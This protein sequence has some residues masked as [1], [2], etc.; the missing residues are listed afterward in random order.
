[1]N[2]NL[3]ENAKLNI[4]DGL[5]N[6]IE[7]TYLIE[8]EYKNLTAS[9]TNLQN[10]I[11][12]IV[13]ILPTAIWV[14]DED[15]SV[16]LQNSEAAKISNLLKFIGSNDGEIELGGMIYLVKTTK[17]D[18]K[19][20]VSAT[21][22]TVEKR[23]ERL[24]SMGQVA[25]HLAHEIRNPVGSIS[26]L[27]STLAKRVDEKS[28]PIVTEI[29]KAIH[30]VERII[31]ATLLFT[32]GLSINAG[33]F[34][35]GELKKECEEAIAYHA[36]SK[37]I[38]FEL[39]FPNA[40]YNGDKDLLAMVFQNILFNAI[41]A[42]EESDDDSGAIR[43]DYEKSEE[44]HKFSVFDSGV[45]IKNS[46]MVFEP[47]KTSKLKGNGLGL[48]LCLQIVQAHKGSIEITLNPKSFCVNLPIFK[49]EN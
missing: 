1:M 34:N 20:I 35:F 16:F 5:K 42:I 47:F 37:N 10:F 21:N 3:D 32:K 27:S 23:T 14:L 28:L 8:Q 49:S 11:T 15:G 7:Q 6:L 31:K 9:Y 24:A 29:Q 13:E 46:E 30:R 12:D 19:K 39:N 41:D 40:Y 18:S 45:G 25:A 22:I 33:V 4:Q 38:S 48:H 26:L 44:E 43:I 2:E 17:K 36:Y